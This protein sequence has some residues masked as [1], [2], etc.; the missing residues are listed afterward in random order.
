M[1]KIILFLLLFVFSLTYCQT[2]QIDY[3]FKVNIYQQFVFPAKLLFD[4]KGNKKYTVLYGISSQV[5]NGF[6]EDASIVDKGVAEYLL[7]SNNL[8]YYFI[9]NEIN[10]KDVFFKDKKLHFTYTLANEEKILNNVR[11]MKATTQLRGRNYTLW[12]DPKSN[13]K[14]GPWKFNDVPGLIYEIYDDTGQY[15][16]ELKSINKIKESLLKNPLA[17]NIFLDYTEYPKL[18]FGYSEKLK[19]N[20]GN[21]PGIYKSELE[22]TTLETVFEWEK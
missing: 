8:P 3:D 15:K 20:F 18:K 17:G 2:T 6:K 22:R 11:L 7:Y 19:N 9:K 13:I 14:Y 16:W 12:Y 5:K 1:K 21:T 10:N 4:T